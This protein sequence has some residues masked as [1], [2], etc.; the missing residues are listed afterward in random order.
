MPRPS[1][2]FFTPLLSSTF[3]SFSWS[4]P[5][6]ST[7]GQ[8][9]PLFS[10]DDHLSP[11][12]S[13]PPSPLGSNLF[14]PRFYVKALS[15]DKNDRARFSSPPHMLSMSN[16]LS[17]RDGGNFLGKEGA[18]LKPFS[19]R[20]LPSFVRCSGVFLFNEETFGPPHI[21]I[22]LSQMFTHKFPGIFRHERPSGK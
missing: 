6:S 2:R 5:S 7:R 20:M 22:F 4:V 11:L 1:Y 15:F 12:A 13:P 19:N 9:V 14:F 3:F 17:F 16:P 18:H 21:A 10:S 8:K